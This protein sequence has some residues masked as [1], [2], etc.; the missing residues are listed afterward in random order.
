M[1]K[2]TF[3]ALFIILILGLMVNEIQGQEEETKSFLPGLCPKVLPDTN[4][5]PNGF[6]C[7][8]LCL[9]KWKGIGGCFPGDDPGSIFCICIFPCKS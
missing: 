6:S 9:L 4:C 2:S 1:T 7:T 8:G 3:F 5:V